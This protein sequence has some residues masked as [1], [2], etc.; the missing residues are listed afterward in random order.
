MGG[1]RGPVPVNGRA[2]LWCIIRNGDCRT[3][4]AEAKV[5]G[6]GVLHESVDTNPPPDEEP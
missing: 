4:K 3:G 5:F 6:G 1:G 2:R